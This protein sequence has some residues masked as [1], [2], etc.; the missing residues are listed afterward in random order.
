M[1]KLKKSKSLD[2]L[3]DGY[4]EDQQFY[5]IDEPDLED[6][7]YDEFIGPDWEDELNSVI[8]QFDK[9]GNRKTK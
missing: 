8:G 4:V 3:P 9:H 6:Y 7:D 2:S 1:G 5:D